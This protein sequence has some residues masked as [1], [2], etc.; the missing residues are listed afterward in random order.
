[1]RYFIPV[2]MVSA[3]WG[4]N[5]LTANYTNDRASANLQE[6]VLTASSVARGFGKIGS[7]PVDGQVYAQ[8]LYVSG[9]AFPTAG[10]HNVVLLATQHNSVYLYDADSVASPQLLWHVNLGPSVPSTTFP[11]FTD[12]KPEVGILSTP[13]IDAQLA[14][15]YVVSYTLENGAPVYRLHALDLT[16]GHEMFNGPTIITASV[17]GTGEG[18]SNGVLVFDPAMHLQRPGLLLANGVVYLAFGSH[19]DASPWHGWVLSYSASDVSFQAGVYNVT[20]NGLGGSIWQ[21]GRGLAADEAGNLYAITGNGDHDGTPTLA[22]S[23]LKLSGAAPVLT[24]SYTP[25]NAQWLSDQDYDLS[26]G[27][28]I[29]PGTHLL[30]GGDKFGQLYLVNGD[31]MS[32]APQVFQGVQWGGIFNLA[33]WSRTDGAYVYVQEQGSVL[34]CYQIVNGKFNTTPVFTS[35]ARADSPY[36]GIMVSAN[37]SLAGTG[38]VW[39][40]TVNKSVASRPGTLHAFDA[41]NLNELWNSD[42]NPADALGA[43]AK[44]VS[45]TVANG[46]V[47]VPTFSNTVTV[48]GLLPTETASAAVPIVTNVI[49]ANAGVNIG[50]GAAVTLTGTNLGPVT[51]AAMQF[52]LSGAVTLTLGGTMV[53]FDG[54]PAPVTFASDRQV[55]AVAP[56]SLVAATT[57]VQVL[58]DGQLSAAFAVPVG[59]AAPEADRSRVT[60]RKPP[61]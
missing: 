50:P 55:N 38:I 22:E 53:L 31:A 34:K 3:A 26:A 27:V 49:G 24:D 51:A 16:S 60:Q 5:V 57:N 45:P 36:D 10:T 17:P 9:V 37:R 18:S 15:A 28:A 19:A 39:E 59:P 20:P 56:L 32:T 29:V 33:I 12:I 30:I 47:Y 42:M 8:P 4:Q 7:L 11:D 44:F 61:R 25:A 46:K 43:F 58:Y 13:V 2:L 48:Y 40:T 21:S 35:T 23:F 41:G 6:R 52:D 1:M 54:I 14:V